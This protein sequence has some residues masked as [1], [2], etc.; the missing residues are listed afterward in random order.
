ME[1]REKSE[2]PY[3]NLNIKDIG[4]LFVNML[5]LCN[6]T[7]QPSSH[8]YIYLSL[9]IHSCQELHAYLF[10]IFCV[11]YVNMTLGKVPFDYNVD[12][13]WLKTTDL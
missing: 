5:K 1:Q 2:R 11:S 12:I 13:A 9:N 7:I 10:N 4:C 3:R 6:P 8:M